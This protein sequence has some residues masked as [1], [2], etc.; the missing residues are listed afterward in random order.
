VHPKNDVTLLGGEEPNSELVRIKDDIHGRNV[1]G[2]GR[3]NRKGRCSPWEPPWKSQVPNKT[4]IVAFEQGK[5]FA[6]AGF[7]YI[8]KK[9]S[10]YARGL[11]RVFGSDKIG[12]GKSKRRF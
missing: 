8:K 6:G 2:G 10:T 5:W 11:N 7:E 1:V 9:K 4:G 3:E 12:E